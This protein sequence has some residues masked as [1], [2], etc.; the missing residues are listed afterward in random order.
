MADLLQSHLVSLCVPLFCGAL[1]LVLGLGVTV[2]AVATV[3][4][5]GPL[6]CGASDR[7]V[8][9]VLTVE[10]VLMVATSSPM[11]A[12]NRK[13][14]WSVMRLACSMAVLLVF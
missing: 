1:D 14:C 13:V 4:S 6:F 3:A 9:L 7:V 12:S 2:E 10:A 8:D 11:A 5:F